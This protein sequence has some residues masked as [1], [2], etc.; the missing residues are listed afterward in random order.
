M[1]NYMYEERQSKNR[2]LLSRLSAYVPTSYRR[3]TNKLREQ[4]EK[5]LPWIG[6]LFFFDPMCATPK[7]FRR[8]SSAKVYKSRASAE[9][10]SRRKILIWPPNSLKNSRNSP[11]PI[12]SLS[13]TPTVLKSRRSRTYSFDLPPKNKISEGSSSIFEPLLSLRGEGRRVIVELRVRYAKT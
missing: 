9:G 8:S 6:F 13:P 5:H 11:L 12:L 1:Q 10:V 4:V 3:R 2:M 7:I